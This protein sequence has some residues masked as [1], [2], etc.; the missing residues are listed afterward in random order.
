[1][2]V[3]AHFLKT[4]MT[5]FPVHHLSLRFAEGPFDVLTLL[6]PLI[7]GLIVFRVSILYSIIEQSSLPAARIFLS[8]DIAMALI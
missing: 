8:G 1:M 7:D 2:R 4:I 3:D 5:L 6:C